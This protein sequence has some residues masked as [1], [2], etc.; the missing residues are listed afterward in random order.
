MLSRVANS[1]YWMA[2]YIERAENTARFVDVAEQMTLGRGDGVDRASGEWSPLI[3]AI[4][5]DETF[6]EAYGTGH[7]GKS[8]P[9]SA[10]GPRKSQLGA[11][12][13]IGRPRERPHRAGGDLQRNVE[14]DQP[15]VPPA[16]Q[17]LGPVG[18]RPR[19]QSVRG[20]QGRQPRLSGHH[21]GHPV[22]GHRLRL[23][24]TGHHAGAGRQDQPPAGR[25]VLP[26]AAHRRARGFTAGSGA[27]VGALAVGQ[28]PRDVSPALRRHHAQKRGALSGA[29]RVLSAFPAVLPLRSASRA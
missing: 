27:V 8:R 19:H 2:R 3:S 11:V 26:V 18:H 29:R 4:A 15:A 20:D 25:E 17:G 14:R 23:P 10:A 7:P 1:I 22:P 12:V 28:C 13:R 24:E 5:D 21:R 9:V 6:A 16:A